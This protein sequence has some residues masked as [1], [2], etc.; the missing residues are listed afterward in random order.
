MWRPSWH[1]YSEERTSIP[2]PMRPQPTTTLLAN[3]YLIFNRLDTYISEALDVEDTSDTQYNGFAPGNDDS[4]AYC[5]LFDEIY[6]ATNHKLGSRIKYE[7]THV[8]IDDV[9]NTVWVECFDLNWIELLFFSSKAI[10][11]AQSL[12]FQTQPNK[13]NILKAGYRMVG[14]IC[15]LWW[16]NIL[17]SDQGR[18]NYCEHECQH[19][20]DCIAWPGMGNLTEEVVLLIFVLVFMLIISLHCF[21]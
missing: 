14:W 2:D 20:L 9:D 1:L 16:K 8:G 12:L 15:N 13:Q 18:L 10:K 17:Q 21:S 7:E 4:P 6:I 11:R 19:G 3:S 5:R